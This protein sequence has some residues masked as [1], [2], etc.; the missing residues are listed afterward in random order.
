[1]QPQ[2]IAGDPKD[3]TTIGPLVSD[4]QYEKVQNLIQKGIDEGAEP[5]IGGTG[6]PN[7]LEKGYY[8]NPRFW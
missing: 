4:V 6:K 3:D 1:M 5:L 8:L 2:G 7:G